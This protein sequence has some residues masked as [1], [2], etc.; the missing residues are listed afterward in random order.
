MDTISGWASA[1]GFGGDVARYMIFVLVGGN[2]L[3]ELGTNIILS[4]IIVRLLNVKNNK[5]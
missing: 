5:K 4:P 2:F 1:L 3:F